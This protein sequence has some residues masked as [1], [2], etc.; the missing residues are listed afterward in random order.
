MENSMDQSIVSQSEAIDVVDGMNR[1]SK[2]LED[3]TVTIREIIMNFRSIIKSIKI[4][5]TKR[6]ALMDNHF[7]WILPQLDNGRGKELFLLIS[8]SI[9]EN[10]NQ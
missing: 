4:C 7:D 2:I 9:E 6:S 8:G 5:L 10:N 1:I 3:R